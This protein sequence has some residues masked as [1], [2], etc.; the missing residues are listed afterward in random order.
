MYYSCYHFTATTLS[1]ISARSTLHYF[2]SGV[3]RYSHAR[4]PVGGWSVS[5]MRI[6]YPKEM[7]LK[8]TDGEPRLSPNAVLGPGGL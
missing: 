3:A 6:R 7:L 2:K 1:D 5:L 8:L 4:F